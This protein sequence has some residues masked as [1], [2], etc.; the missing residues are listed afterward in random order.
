MI[1][2]CENCNG[3]FVI[4]RKWQRFC[5][6]KCKDSYNNEQKRLKRIAEKEDKN[7]N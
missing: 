1:V 2:N 5:S 6:V 3:V 4:K 7:A